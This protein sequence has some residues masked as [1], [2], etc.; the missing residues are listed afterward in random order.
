MMRLPKLVAMTALA[1]GILAA[2]LAL[3]AEP[4][5]AGP[6]AQ[7]GPWPVAA[8]GRVAMSLGGAWVWEEKFKDSVQT[9]AVSGDLA[10][11][12]NAS[13]LHFEDDRWW[14][15]RVAYGLHPRLTAHLTLGQVEGGRLWQTLGADSWHAV[16]RPG[17][18]YGG[19]LSGL[20]WQGPQGWG[21]RA[22]AEYLRY[23]NRG[24]ATWID[25]AGYSSEANGSDATGQVD[26]WRLTGGAVVYKSWGAFTPWAGISLAY[27]EFKENDRDAYNPDGSIID[28][29]FA[30]KSA[31]IFGLTAGV[32]WRICPALSLGVMGNFLNRSEAGLTLSYGF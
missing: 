19:G 17:L 8:P 27:A 25:P 28:Y 20:V 5:A 13:D 6:A 16:L 23:D 3:A 4:P 22:G 2:G 9:A 11:R 29:D 14:L 10:Y 26:Y 24:I 18:V 31:D 30:S 7:A 15:V 12:N 32:D 21:V 1:A